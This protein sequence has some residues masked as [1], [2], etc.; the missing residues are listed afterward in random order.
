MANPFDF[1]HQRLGAIAAD[2]AFTFTPKNKS[3]AIAKIDRL[4]ELN[5]IIKEF[6]TLS[7]QY[8]HLVDPERSDVYRKNLDVLDNLRA[9]VSMGAAQYENS[10]AQFT[11]WLNDSRAYVDIQMNAIVDVVTQILK[12]LLSSKDINPKSF[13]T[14]FS[15]LCIHFRNIC[16]ASISHAQY[17]AYVWGKFIRTFSLCRGIP[18]AHLIPDITTIHK[19]LTTVFT[20]SDCKQGMNFARNG[21]NEILQFEEWKREFQT[22][23]V[24]TVPT[25]Q[26][27]AAAKNPSPLQPS[28]Q[29]QSQSPTG[30]STPLLPS[31]EIRSQSAKSNYPI[32][33]KVQLQITKPVVTV[34]TDVQVPILTIPAT[35]PPL[36]APAIRS[37]TVPLR[38]SVPPTARD[39]ALSAPVNIGT[40][41]SPS[42]KNPVQREDKR[43]IT[44]PV[45]FDHIM[46]PTEPQQSTTQ[47]SVS[48]TPQLS[49]PEARPSHQ[50]LQDGLVEQTLSPIDIPAT[51]QPRQSIIKTK[52]NKPTDPAMT[53]RFYCDMLLP[54]QSI[55]PN[56]MRSHTFAIDSDLNHRLLTGKFQV[57]IS[58]YQSGH[59]VRHFPRITNFVLNGYSL[60]QSADDNVTQHVELGTNKLTVSAAAGQ[61]CLG[62][63]FCVELV[64]TAQSVLERVKA[65]QAITHHKLRTILRNIIGQN[66][67]AK[68]V[69][70]LH[71][72]F[73][74]GRRKMR[75]ANP[76][77]PVN[78]THV[79]CFDLFDWIHASE[80]SRS[81]K[82][83]CP[84]CGNKDVSLASLR[85]D[86][87]FESW[88]E[89]APEGVEYII[90]DNEGR[91]SQLSSVA[92]LETMYQAQL[93]SS[94]MPKPAL[95]EDMDIHYVPDSVQTAE[96]SED[97]GVQSISTRKHL[98]DPVTVFQPLSKRLKMGKTE[99][100]LEIHNTSMKIKTEDQLE[101]HNTSM[102]I[103]TEDL[104]EI[105][106]TS[107]NIKPESRDF[108]S[109]S[110]EMAIASLSAVSQQ[111][112]NDQKSSSINQSM[113]E[114]KNLAAKIDT[115]AVFQGIM[116]KKL[117][118]LQPADKSIS[119][120]TVDKGEGQE[121]EEE[122][123]NIDVERVT[124]K[125]AFEETIIPSESTVVQPDI[126]NTTQN[127][128][129][130]SMQAIKNI[131]A[132]IDAKAIFQGLM[133][134][135]W[136]KHTNS[137]DPTPIHSSGL[138]HPSIIP[139]V[140]SFTFNI[141]ERIAE[142]AE[143]GSSDSIVPSVGQGGEGMVFPRTD[144]HMQS[145]V[146]AV[147]EP[148]LTAGQTVSKRSFYK[149]LMRNSKLGLPAI[150]EE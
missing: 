72:G 150:D 42:P 13:V 74:G 22:T 44:A 30:W 120:A 95:L 83:S 34:S 135:K 106:N 97:E 51:L 145:E 37:K 76:V 85:F 110:G 128:I 39:S 17:L 56:Q 80:S 94:D 67:G 45:S 60:N 52:Q 46:V 21:E 90:V 133:S 129:N 59:H 43:P 104:L 65:L 115:K 23:S 68:V 78:C 79:G 130:Q 18:L 139:A 148:E 55:Q 4:F 27:S 6:P 93:Q 98:L 54:M 70:D 140:P 19:D 132:K 131:A 48:P 124:T 15:I 53:S 144:Y 86:T 57:V 62:V 105:H 143:E 10:V 125:L 49:V 28:D 126:T 108:D 99:D 102:N 14:I 107:M 136:S 117:P 24:Q 114:V 149:T 3:E 63:E 75:I 137:K 112:V 7:E 119:A 5:A 123:M 92:N 36:T 26:S 35:T 31:C 77:R 20:A 101:I 81:S 103:K 122:S 146:G 111:D 8:P 69:V 82:P 32:P 96:Q 16:S 58:F 2:R 47:L 121:L 118:K 9:S 91:F 138:T 127:S 38:I 88:L 71:L 64:E 61:D 100:L 40:T 142:Q 33:Q 25:S 84:I 73:G 116:S 113:L 41:S 147:E 1:W 29:I 11:V 109:A 89:E 141:A 66:S 134:K 50:K 87:L 12:A